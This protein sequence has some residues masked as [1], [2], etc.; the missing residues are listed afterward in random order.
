MR[1]EFPKPEALSNGFSNYGNNLIYDVLLV[2]G[3]R[4]EST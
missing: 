3:T 2:S 1:A 4:L